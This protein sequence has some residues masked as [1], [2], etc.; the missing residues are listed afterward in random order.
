MKKRIYIYELDCYKVASE[1]QIQRMRISPERY[2]NL[3]GLP[4][5]ELAEKLEE[6]I[7]E[8]GKML[9]PSSMASEVTYY[10]NIREFLIDRKIQSLDAREEEKII[11]M[12]KGWM[13][14]RG[15]AL[16]SKKYR[17]AYDK[18]GIESPG[19]VRHMKKILKF[20]EEEDDRDEQEKDIWTLKNFDFPIYGNP[21]KNTET[22]NF[23]KIV[24]PDI[25]EEVK[26]VIFMHLKYSPLG[27]IHSEIAAVKR[28]SKFLKRKYLDIQS[29]Q[30]LERMHIEEYLIYLSNDFPSTPRYVFKFYSDA[31][32]KRLNEHI[33][34]M[35]EQICRALIIHQL[36]GTRISDTLTLK[37]DCISMRNNRYFI[38]IDQV[39]SVTYEKAISEEVAQLIM[40]AIDYTKERYGETTYIFTKKDDP[41]R[42]YQY[43]MIQNQ[44]MTMIRQEDIRD[45]NGEFLKFGT[46]IFRHCYGKKL[47]E[48]HVDDWM[49]AKLLGHTSIYSVHH[50]RKI[51]NKLM[52][53]E[54]RAAREKMDMILLDIIEG[55]D[56]YEI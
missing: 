15:Y 28:F 46:H 7:W 51:G 3:E 1:E 48:M 24:Q 55:W 33:F 49:I 22:I 54:T 23:T 47:T 14:E 12:L 21:I 38:R 9:A 11:R 43:S 27:T 53:D 17:P 41:T 37:T 31:E 30:D 39:K 44:I 16:S 36:L 10:N 56:D 40:K 19:I 4:S 2:F 34:K 18:I 29:L 20:L 6:F 52:A 32:I 8:R 25:R 50:Y 5:E 26:K 13:L 45:D 42:P 35:D